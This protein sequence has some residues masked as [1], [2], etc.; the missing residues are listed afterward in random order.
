MT[1]PTPTLNPYALELE[2]EQWRNPPQLTHGLYAKLF[3]Q[4]ITSVIKNELVPEHLLDVPE[5]P[6][7]HWRWVH[8]VLGLVS[9]QSELFA[10]LRPTAS[11][12]MFDRVNF[13]EELGDR[14][15]YLALL[16]LSVSDLTDQKAANLWDKWQASSIEHLI[17]DSAPLEVLMDA[18]VDADSKLADLSKRV[19]IYSVKPTE[20]ALEQAAQ[21]AFCLTFDLARR[22][23]IDIRAILQA[24]VRKLWA[25]KA[26]ATAKKVE[27][28]DTNRDLAK[29]RAVL[30][31]STPR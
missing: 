30:E 9:E 13:I 23:G 21:G 3:D 16:A 25:R 27:M 14:F 28:G 7:W 2:L 5:A 4:Y 10:Q 19:L 11:R 8:G 31:Q 1:E 22:S 29:E 6:L 20:S 17:H 18:I 15:W 12:L 24:N 26:D